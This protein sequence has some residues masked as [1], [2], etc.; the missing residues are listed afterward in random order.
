MAEQI[1]HEA[2]FKALNAGAAK[3][4]ELDEPSSLAIL[5]QGGNLLAF[6]RVGDAALSTVEL[7]HNKA[8]TALSLRSPSG[9]WMDLVQP[10]ALYYGL[11]N[12]GG[13]RPYVVF[14]GGLPIRDGKTVIGAVG[15]SGGPA[16]KDVAIAEA[17]LS[18]LGT[19]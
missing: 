6:L 12:H 9:S 11:D 10:G 13:R 15:V 19:S 1:T 17:M 2:A 3:A 5:D 4:L 16:E 8:H 14:G 18:A 7:A